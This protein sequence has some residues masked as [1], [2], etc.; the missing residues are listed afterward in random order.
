M[1]GTDLRLA[2]ELQLVIPQEPVELVT[3]EEVEE[4]TLAQYQQ[5]KQAL[6]TR[7]KN[8]ALR[9]DGRKLQQ[10]VLV[11]DSMDIILERMIS[12]G[13]TSMDFKNLSE[14]YERMSKSLN[15]ISRLDSIDGMGHSARLSLEI[16]F[17]G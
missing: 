6:E 2:N 13:N 16:K 4:L 7:R 8:L 5:A 11:M 17:E 12:E 1:A 15:T 9:L 10:A 14:A 3:T